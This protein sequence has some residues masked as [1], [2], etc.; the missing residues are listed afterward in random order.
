MIKLCYVLSN[1]NIGGAEKL[2]IDVANLL[3]SKEFEVSIIC[4]FTSE[5]INLK[6]NVRAGI[7]VKELSLEKLGF[8]T[9]I[10]ALKK[11]LQEF[12]II[13]S[14]S[15]DSH[16]YCSLVKLLYI[17]K[18]KFI[19]TIHGVESVFI[20][21]KNLRKIV[22]KWP[23]K[24]YFL[25]R[26]YLTFGFQFYTSFLS[27][28]EHSK[29]QF[30]KNR[31][32]PLAKIHMAYHGILLDENRVLEDNDIL[33]KLNAEL[34]FDNNKIVLGYVGRLT[35]AKGIEDLLTV[36][37]KLSREIPDLRLIFVGD[38]ELRSYV[39]N[40]ISVNVLEEKCFILGFS[41]NVKAYYKL[42][43][44]FVLPSKSESTSM[45]TQEAM[46]NGTLCLCSNIGG[47]D[48]II[49]SGING[50]LF[51]NKEIGDFEDKLRWCLNNLNNS[52]EIKLDATNTIKNKFDL[53]KNALN[54]SKIL[55][56]L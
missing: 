19:M 54:I 24:Y 11:E 1:L 55:K 16:V 3:D 51:N 52:E 26:Y 37:N 49:E 38:G 22:K 25:L 41:K 53:R 23:F 33:Q 39:E 18:K 17:S 56:N 4:M 12:D 28:C 43:D 15:E 42:L 7:P 34:N 36:F 31:K 50:I 46:L 9:K 21:D 35:Y 47:I 48:E 20:E 44:V 8:L 27:V 40:F 13:H 2:T 6:S 10:K 5:K 45:V 32:I 30:S 29:I 14:S